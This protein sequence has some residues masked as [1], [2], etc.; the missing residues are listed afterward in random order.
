M[1]PVCFTD[2]SNWLGASRFG[3]F[4]NLNLGG[5]SSN[6]SATAN[7]GPFNRTGAVTELD[8]IFK[9]AF[10]FLTSF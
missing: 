1:D 9:T 8:V 4:W 2:L 10:M 5:M 7:P 6:Q 3:S